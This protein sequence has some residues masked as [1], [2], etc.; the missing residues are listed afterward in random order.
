M[1]DAQEFDN[2]IGGSDP[3]RVPDLQ[4]ASPASVPR[5]IKYGRLKRRH[6]SYRSDYWEKL[7]A[8]YKG[9]DTLFGNKRVML[10]L[11]PRHGDEKEET[12]RKRCESASYENYASMIIGHLVDGLFQDPVRIEYGEE[13]EELRVS[14]D[15]D[16]EEPAERPDRPE[17]FFDTFMMDASAPGGIEQSWNQ[18]L[19]EL[20]VEAFQV[21]VGWMLIDTPDMGPEYQPETRLDEEREGA[22][23]PWAVMLPAEEVINWKLDSVKEL[24]WALTLRSEPVIETIMDDGSLIRETYHLRTREGWG[25]YV[26]EYHKDNM[27]PEGVALKKR[28]EDKDDIPI[29]SAG[30]YNY[31]GKVPMVR[32]DFTGGLWAL[33]LLC[34]NLKAHFNMTSALDWAIGRANF[35]QL[36]EFLAPA[37]AG[38]DTE[39]NEHQADEGR[40]KNQK[41]G[42][43]FVQVRGKDDSASYVA[44]PTEAFEFTQTRLDRKRDEIF[45]QFMAMALSQDNSTASIRRTAESKQQDKASIAVI[46]KGIGD[47]LVAM[48]R[49]TIA[50]LESLR[51][52]TCG[53]SVVGFEKFDPIALGDSIEQNLAIDTLNIPSATFIKSRFKTLARR[54]LAGEV[55]ADVLAL[56]DEEIDANVTD[57]MVQAMVRPEPDPMEMALLKA[58]GAPPNKGK[59]APKA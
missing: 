37:V 17:T 41:R 27:A 33:D 45:R 21:G 2:P 55:E 53:G 56:I 47:M 30:A 35:P 58:T 1:H 31:D 23:D 44:A 42:V 28:P 20:V 34:R 13:V 38:I 40:A 26:V 3:T 8:L 49:V 6:E 24:K 43:G 48:T 5:S 7:R 22:N 19:R 52:E 54:F 25:R 32:L 11:F 10:E 36:Y 16:A 50:L 57:D 14:G 9:G 12:W 15:E 46:L 4:V 51:D 59:N 18:F 29:E 39:I